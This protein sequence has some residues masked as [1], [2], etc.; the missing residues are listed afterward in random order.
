MLSFVKNSDMI[1]VK[2]HFGE[3]NKT[4][5]ARPI[6]IKKVGELIKEKKGIP[7]ATETSA[8]YKGKRSDA[9][10]HI[11]HAYEMGYDFNAIGMPIIMADGLYGH[12]EIEVPIN[13][14]E[15]E[16]VN[17]AALV[18]KIQGMVVVSHF[19]GHLAAGF[20]A[21]LKNIGMGLSSRKGKL[22]Q[23]STAQP[24]IK[25]K[26]C[27]SCGVCLKWCPA[28][29]ITMSDECAVIDANKCIGCG[30]CLAMCRFDAVA[31]NWSVTYNDLQKK[32]T[33]HALGVVKACPGPI[34]FIN[35]L[36]RISKDCDCMPGYEPIVPD[37]GVLLCSDP[38]AIDAASL[39]L[40]EKTMGKPFSESAYDIPYRIQIEH[41]QK[42]KFGN[43]D[44]ELEIIS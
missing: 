14:E 42:I 8:L 13:C 31:Y 27:N 24:A 7:F 9:V 33:E 18:D 34:L 43:A 40:V 36:T 29:A 10:R 2:T 41:A 37:I 15:Y 28:D 17:V 26:Q 32:I 22:L 35:V 11:E 23:H 16:T 4:G 44:Y 12:E 5:V 39:D 1:A 21:A 20:G 38:V 25:K 3:S 6:I 19:T 30:E